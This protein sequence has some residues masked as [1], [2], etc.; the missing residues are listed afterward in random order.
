MGSKKKKKKIIFFFLAQT[1]GNMAC[2]VLW[3]FEERCGAH[4]D[5]QVLRKER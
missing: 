2:C 3:K 4:F 1:N 5:Y